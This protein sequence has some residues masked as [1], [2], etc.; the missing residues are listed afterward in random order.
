M[1]SGIQ[2]EMT[3][4]LKEAGDLVLEM[5]RLVTPKCSSELAKYQEEHVDSGERVDRNTADIIKDAT[6][7]HNNIVDLRSQYIN[8][9]EKIAISC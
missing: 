1:H 6:K 4:H 2:T 7:D 8:T 3:L 9:S 5:L